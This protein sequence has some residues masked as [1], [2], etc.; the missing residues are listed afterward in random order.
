MLYP[1]LA[2][3]AALL[4]LE[5]TYKNINEIKSILP[6][7]NYQLWFL[8]EHSEK[9]FY[10]NDEPHGISLTSLHTGNQKEFLE[11]IFNECN[12]NHLFNTFKPFR[13]PLWAMIPVGC[14]HY[15]L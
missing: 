14:R 15:R 11:M 3:I 6:H 9:K 4:G 7:C 8:D 12:R 13:L 10:T 5:D 1:F 2:L